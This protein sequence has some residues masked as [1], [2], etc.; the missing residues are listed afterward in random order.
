MQKLRDLNTLILNNC[1]FGTVPSGIEY[2]PNIES[3][4]LT[5][6]QNIWCIPSIDRIKSLSLKAS[7]VNLFEIS[8]DIDWSEFDTSLTLPLYLEYVMRKRK[9]GLI[10][11]SVM[12]FMNRYDQ[13]IRRTYS[14]IS[15]SELW[16]LIRPRRE[17]GGDMVK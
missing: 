9:I 14:E 8:K 5:G 6:C 10:M 12:T 3:L 7:F 13:L 11:S 2:I 4:D 1:R 17:G 15:I 16:M